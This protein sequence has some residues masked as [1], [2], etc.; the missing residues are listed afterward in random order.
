MKKFRFVWVGSFKG[1]DGFVKRGYLEKKK[2]VNLLLYKIGLEVGEK[3]VQWQ[4]NLV[5]FIERYVSFEVV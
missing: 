3:F 4:S 5:E 1:F 2:L